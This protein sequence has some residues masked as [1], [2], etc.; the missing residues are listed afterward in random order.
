MF[1]EILL[2]L[3]KG[4][5]DNNFITGYR[6]NQ[7]YLLCITLTEFMSWMPISVYTYYWVLSDLYHHPAWPENPGGVF[8]FVNHLWYENYCANIFRVEY[9]LP[10]LIV[11]AITKESLYNAFEHGITA[12]Q[13][14]IDF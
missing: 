4:W 6:Y 14:S 10:N 12:D 2:M 7:L 11:A 3:I 8:I 9:Q 5:N 13:A 1:L